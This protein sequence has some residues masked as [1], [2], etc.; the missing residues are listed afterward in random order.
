MR[1][2]VFHENGGPDVIRAED[3]ALP[4]PPA[5]WVRLRVRASALNHL[6]LWVRRGLPIETVM[7]HIGG[8]DIAGTLDAFGTGAEASVRSAFPDLAPDDVFVVD[9]SVGCGRCEWC[10]RAD[11]PLCPEYQIIGEH[12]QGGFAEFVIV[13][14]ANLY[15]IPAGFDATRAAA[16]PLVYL[17]AWRALVTRARLRAGE[18]LVVTGASGGVATAAVQIGKLLGARVVAVSTA[19]HADALRALG[20]ETVY[21]RTAE[22]WSK[23]LW[24]DTDKR[25]ADVI[26]DSV[27]TAFFKQNVR[28]LARGGRLVIYGATTGPDAQFDL[29]VLFWKQAEIIGTTM[30]THAEFEA[31]MQHVFSGALNPVVDRVLPLADA[32]SAHELLEQ[33]AV[34]GKIV[35][36]P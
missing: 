32:R 29:R 24:R 16:A 10:T 21:D 28:A 17:T 15:R 8:S 13:P 27:G 35:L 20:A 5:G 34:F 11:V 22:D 9:P 25:G 2:A 19:E 26:I 31:V 3:V 30:S 23:S 1:A 14:A 6:D 18:T 4:E 7:P 36:T 12:L 33:G